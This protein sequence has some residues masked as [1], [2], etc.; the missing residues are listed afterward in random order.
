MNQSK[1]PCSIIDK[2][3]TPSLIQTKLS[4]KLIFDNIWAGTYCTFAKVNDKNDIFVFGL[5]NYNQI[6]KCVC[7]FTQT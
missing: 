4:L 6:G 3:L 5:N 2:L 7:T 1:R